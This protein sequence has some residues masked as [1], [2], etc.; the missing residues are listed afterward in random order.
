MFNSAANPAAAYRKSS[1]DTR[2]LSASPHQLVALLFDGLLQSIHA[3]RGALARADVPTKGEQIGRAVRILE[4]GLKAGLDLQQGGE[5]A[6]NL[7]TLY[8]YCIQ[9][10]TDANLHGDVGALDEVVRLIG[11]VA[12]SWQ[13]IAPLPLLTPARVAAWPAHGIAAAQL[14]RAPARGAAAYSQG[15]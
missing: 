10:L 4:E 14:S 12:D 2:V 8:S 5:V 1:V 9:R 11:T 6:A 3:A 15:V 13:Q 7:H